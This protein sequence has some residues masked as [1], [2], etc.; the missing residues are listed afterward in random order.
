M[1]CEA[2]CPCV[3]QLDLFSAIVNGDL[4][5]DVCLADP[6][7]LSVVVRDGSFAFISTSTEPP[8][9]SANLEPPFITLTA[10]EAM[11]CRDLLRKAAQA[12]GIECVQPE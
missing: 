11:V 3:E 4:T 7:L 1:P 10:D 5:V 9:C 6:D 8:V 12:Q 2:S